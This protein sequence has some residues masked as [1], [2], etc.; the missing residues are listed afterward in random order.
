MSSMTLVQT[1][2][3]NE[4]AQRVEDFVRTVVIPL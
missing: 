2:R 4:I 3:G 1:Q